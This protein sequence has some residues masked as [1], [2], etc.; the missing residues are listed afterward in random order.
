VLT[1]AILGSTEDPFVGLSMGQR[2]VEK[3][4]FGVAMRTT[5]DR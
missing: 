3:G 1:M 5:L 4:R 2:N